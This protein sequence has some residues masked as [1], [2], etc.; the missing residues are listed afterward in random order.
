MFVNGGDLNRIV[1]VNADYRS[2]LCGDDRLFGMSC[3][4]PYQQD[5]LKIRSGFF[6]NQGS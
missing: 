5:Y 6:I 1:A 3:L 4:F 2:A